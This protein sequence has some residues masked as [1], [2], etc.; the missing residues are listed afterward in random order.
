MPD[1]S[2]FIPNEQILSRYLPKMCYIYIKHINLAD[3]FVKYANTIYKLNY[4]F[5]HLKV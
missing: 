4:I 2:T 5:L 3:L 1:Q